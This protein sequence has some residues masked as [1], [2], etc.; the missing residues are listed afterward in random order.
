M[1]KQLTNINT[2]E[3]VLFMQFKVVTDKKKTISPANGKDFL[4]L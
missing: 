2:K 3:H 4:K 1:A